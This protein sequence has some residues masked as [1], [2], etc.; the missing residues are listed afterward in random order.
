MG[1][2]LKRVRAGQIGLYKDIWKR[3]IAKQSNFENTW[4]KILHNG[5]YN[6]ALL[7]AQGVRSRNVSLLSLTDQKIGFFN[8]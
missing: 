1:Y 2:D 7:K 5:I 6:K 8:K 3:K 4:N